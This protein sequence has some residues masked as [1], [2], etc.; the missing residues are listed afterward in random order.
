MASTLKDTNAS[1]VYNTINTNNVLNTERSEIAEFYNGR[2][3]FI[4]G[5]TGFMGKVIAP[6]F[7]EIWVK[8]ITKFHF[9]ALVEKLLRSCS[10]IKNIYLLV[11]PKRGHEIAERM[12]ELL[13]G[14]V[15]QTELAGI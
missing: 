2:S 9:K 1:S 13:N 11:R 8:V 3:V 12:V 14:P 7:L 5:G 4:T 10:G 15:S 6:Y